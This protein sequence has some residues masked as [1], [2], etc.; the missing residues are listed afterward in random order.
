MGRG[1]AGCRWRPAEER[2]RCRPQPELPAALVGALT[3]PDR[4]AA[5]AL[6]HSA[7]GQMGHFIEPAIAPLGFDW[8]IGVGLVASLA[9]REVIVATLGQIYAAAA[10]GAAGVASAG[11]GSAGV[12]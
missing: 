4:E 2:T 8:K 10:P 11:M 3:S 12:A 6:E 1:R 5:Y 7:A 9:A